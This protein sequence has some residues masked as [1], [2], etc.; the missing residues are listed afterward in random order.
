MHRLFP[1]S[2]KDDIFPEYQNTPVGLLLEYNNLNREYEAYTQAQLLIGMC[3][4]NRKHLH[5]PD[6]F[7][8]IIRAGGA[9]LRYS[10]FKVSYAIA[11]GGVTCIALIGHNQCGMVNLMSRKE[12]FIQGLVERAGWERELAEQHFTNFTPMFEIGN[13]IDFVLSEAQRLRSRY[14]KIFVAPLFYK[15]EDN[16]LYQVKNI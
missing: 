14:P 1:V 4:D 3:M 16:L 13:E 12:A 15:V 7:A 9:N 11:V 6:N 10:E 8:Y 5:I 2:T